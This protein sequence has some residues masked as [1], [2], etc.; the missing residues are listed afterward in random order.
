MLPDIIEACREIVSFNNMIDLL[1]AKIGRRQVS[2]NNEM[3]EGFNN[4]LYEK[5]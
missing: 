3:Y 1:K 4:K 2:Y 5:V